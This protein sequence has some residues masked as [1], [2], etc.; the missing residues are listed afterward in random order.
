L[1]RLRGDRLAAVV[2]VHGADPRPEQA[3]V[4]VDLGR[5]ADGRARVAR[6]RLL[7]DRDRGRQPLDRIDV[8]LVHLVEELARVGR[9]RLDI[10]ALPLGVDRIE[11]ERRLSRTGQPRDH[12]ELVARDLD[13]DVLQVVLART[14]DDDLF[15]WGDGRWVIHIAA[16]RCD[17][18]PYS[19]NASADRISSTFTLSLL[20]QLFPPCL[21]VS[22]DESAPK[23]WRTPR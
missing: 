16:L 19:C 10:A 12:H 11:R 17:E 1:D 14:L 2:A 15:H 13:V 8:G 9:Q 5:R 7:F 21:S 4:I 22:R 3:Q 23:L 20:A 18:L 6:S